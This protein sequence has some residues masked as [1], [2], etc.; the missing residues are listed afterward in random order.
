MVSE[1]PSWICA[2]IL[3]SARTFVINSFFFASL[4][5]EQAN[6]M[7]DMLTKVGCIYFFEAFFCLTV[8]EQAFKGR[9]LEVIDQAQHFAALGHASLGGPSV[10]TAQTFREGL[11]STEREREPSWLWICYRFADRTPKSFLLRKRVRNEQKRGMKTA[12]VHDDEQKPQHSAF[13]SVVLMLL[14]LLSSLLGSIVLLKLLLRLNTFYNYWFFRSCALKVLETSN[15]IG[16]CTP[17]SA[18]RPTY[19]IGNMMKRKTEREVINSG[20]RS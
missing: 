18:V 15:L 5:D 11:D 7:S 16:F 12:N 9:L 3:F 8:Y 20:V 10:N 14:T 17:A 1:R 6:D 19:R 4:S 2:R 13:I